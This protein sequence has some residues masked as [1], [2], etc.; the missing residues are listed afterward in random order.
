MSPFFFSDSLALLSSFVLDAMWIDPSEIDPEYLLIV[1]NPV[2]ELSWHS[3]C[4]KDA[5]ILFLVSLFSQRIDGYF[6]FTASNTASKLTESNLK[7]KVTADRKFKRMR[8]SF[9]PLGRALN[10]RRNPHRAR[11][12]AERGRTTAKCAVHKKN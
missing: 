5:P 7:Y 2:T 3:V 12:K 1:I 11:S 4:G 8:P 6:D 10:P 9:T